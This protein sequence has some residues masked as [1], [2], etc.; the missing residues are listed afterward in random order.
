M[1]T[2][3]TK[4]S[5]FPCYR[6][7]PLVRCGNTIYYGD[8]KEPFVIKMDVKST[9]A[10]ANRKIADEISIQLM[11]TDNHV[12]ITNQVVKTSKK[13]GLYSAM[14][15]AQAWLERALVNSED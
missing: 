13:K 14:D 2:K 6:G 8:M 7:K 10:F 12:S 3:L 11:R 5:P 4:T 9:K 1:K 15:I